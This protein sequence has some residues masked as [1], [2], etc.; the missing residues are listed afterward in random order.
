MHIA[1][2]QAYRSGLISEKAACTAGGKRWTDVNALLSLVNAWIKGANILMTGRIDANHGDLCS[3]DG[4]LVA[5]HR[6]F[7]AAMKLI[8]ESLG[9]D[10][11]SD[12][13]QEV[14]DALR[15][16]SD[17]IRRRKAVGK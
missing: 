16:R 1:Y 7:R 8:A 17:E 15:A 10:A 9:Q 2:A 4:L 12:R 13:M 11:V 3:T 14:A 5:A 6:E